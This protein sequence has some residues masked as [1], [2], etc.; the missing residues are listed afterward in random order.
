M[1][2]SRCLVRSLA[3]LHKAFIRPFIRVEALVN[4]QSTFLYKALIALL[5]FKRFLTR[6]GTLVDCQF[7]GLHKVFMA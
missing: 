6:V 4:Y 2:V 1:W 7:A 3:C 5:T